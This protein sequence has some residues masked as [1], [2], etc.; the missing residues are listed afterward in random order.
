M[1]IKFI[2]KGDSDWKYDNKT[3]IFIFKIKKNF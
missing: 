3:L 2:L 1:N